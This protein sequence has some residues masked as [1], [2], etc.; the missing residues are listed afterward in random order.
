MRSFVA[1]FDPRRTRRLLGPALRLCTFLLVSS[2]CSA[3]WVG[4]A[5]GRELGQLALQGGGAL[6]GLAAQHRAQGVQ[7][8]RL[9]GAELSLQSATVD[10]PLDRVLDEA[11]HAC[12]TRGT[13]APPLLRR[14]L[15]LDGVVDERSSSEGTVA[16]FQREGVFDFADLSARLREAA[17]TGELGPLGRLR[18]IHARQDD[19]GRTAVLSLWSEGELDVT[20]LFPSAGDAPGSD[21]PELPRPPGGRRVLSAIHDQIATPLVAYRSPHEI[22]DLQGRYAAQLRREGFTVDRPSSS[23]S[24][25]APEAEL[26]TV[27]SAQAVRFIAFVRADGSTWVVSAPLP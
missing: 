21:D 2:A 1:V 12:A 14:L 7:R 18:L 25:S 6:W 9:N 11:H 15:A 23:A 13:G 20:D 19:G 16:C 10:A 26:W 27:R 17:N 5:L 8:L 24:G 22:G 4:H 3:A